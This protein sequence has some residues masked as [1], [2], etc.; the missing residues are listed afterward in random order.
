MKISAFMVCEYAVVENNG[1]A[2]LIGAGIDGIAF[3]AGEPV[4]FSIFWFVEMER[5]DKSGVQIAHI[6]GGDG[7]SASVKLHLDELSPRTK[8]S[9][10]V[11]MQPQAERV[12][13]YSLSLDG[14]VETRDTHVK[15]YLNR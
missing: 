8:G 11:L 3:K 7:F 9:Y 6:N 2:H 5:G 1:R 15:L 14:H 13:K 4:A 10:R 12:L